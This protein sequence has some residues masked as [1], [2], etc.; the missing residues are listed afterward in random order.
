MLIKAFHKLPE[1]LID[2]AFIDTSNIDKRIFDVELIVLC[3]VENTLLGEQGAASVF[4]PQKG[5]SAEDVK[6]GSSACKI[7]R[8]NASANKQR[9][10]GY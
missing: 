5:A 3:D 1:G 2:L 6:T 10:G 4:G 8:Y 7:Q 9:H